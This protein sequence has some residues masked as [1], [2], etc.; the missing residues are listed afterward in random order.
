VGECCLAVFFFP[1]RCGGSCECGIKSVVE[2]T[3]Y[4]A[5]N[6]LHGFGMFILVKV[7]KAPLIIEEH[8]F[9]MKI[10]PIKRAFLV[11]SFAAIGL[12]LVSPA[13]AQQ[14]EIKANDP[15][16]EE[17]PSPDVNIGGASKRFKPKDWLEMEV[18]FEAKTKSKREEPKS[19]FFDKITVKWYIAMKDPENSKKLIL[20]EKEITHVNIPVGEEVFSSVYL[21]PS[22]LKRLNG[23]R[24]GGGK[25]SLEVVGGEISYQGRP[26]AR[27]TSQKKSGWPEK[28]WWNSGSLSRSDTIQVF[29]KNET[30]FKPFWYDRYAEI[31]EKK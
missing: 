4:A 22:S 28:P 30:P 23:G 21:S 3:M 24:E 20:L 16:F 10:K 29:N 8:L 19:G 25:N 15:K 2:F 17:L 31:E 18:S 6:I 7:R 11:A 27:F 9:T 5:K 14:I 13:V 12:G 26:L 1:F